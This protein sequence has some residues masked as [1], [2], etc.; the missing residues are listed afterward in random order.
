MS[1]D[2]P[3]P[4]HS[5]LAPESHQRPPPYFRHVPRTHQYWMYM[6]TNKGR[7]V[8]YTGVTND[9]QRRLFEHRTGQDPNGFAWNYQCW[10]LVYFESFK[11]VKQAIAREKQVK[12]WERAWKEELI[13]T[14]NPEWNDLSKDWDYR[15]W[16]DP[17]DPPRGFYTQNRV[18]HWGGPEVQR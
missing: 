3:Q 11:Y 2:R 1:L 16:Y 12:N 5:G 17:A 4:C 13:A 9:L 10:T 18:E 7:T 8:L 6:L 15:G 14:E